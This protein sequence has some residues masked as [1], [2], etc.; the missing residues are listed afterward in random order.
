VSGSTARADVVGPGIAIDCGDQ[1]GFPQARVS[2]GEGITPRLLERTWDPDL[3]VSVYALTDSLRVT[4]RKGIRDGVPCAELVYD[5]DALG[6]SRIGHGDL[7]ARPFADWLARHAPRLQ[8]VST[9]LASVYG[10]RWFVVYRDTPGALALKLRELRWMRSPVGVQE[11]VDAWRS[12]GDPYSP[13]IEFGEHHQ[14]SLAKVREAALDF[15]LPRGGF[16]DLPPEVDEAV[17]HW[18]MVRA[19]G[20]PDLGGRFRELH[21]TFSSPL[22]FLLDDFTPR[23]QAVLLKAA[24][25]SHTETSWL[26]HALGRTAMSTGD[27]ALLERFSALWAGWT[28]LQVGGIAGDAFD[29]AWLDTFLRSVVLDGLVDVGPLRLEGVPWKEAEISLERDGPGGPVRVT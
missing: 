20:G 4:E 19:L 25:G 18:G 7:D 1:P 13:A 9:Q 15:V 17:W 16:S 6:P 23:E 8:T 28:T 26:L 11:K 12:G 27:R 21:P 22:P 2:F 24:P 29:S 3:L 5:G 14:L 10:Y